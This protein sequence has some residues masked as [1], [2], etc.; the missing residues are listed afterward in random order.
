[1]TAIYVSVGLLLISAAF[2]AGWA[3][4]SRRATREL[5]QWHYVTCAAYI[6]LRKCLDERRDDLRDYLT[7]QAEIQYRCWRSGPRIDPPPFSRDTD[8]LFAVAATEFAAQ[9]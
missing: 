9:D 7:G 8:Q 5:F 3:F 1:M 4:G 2:V 6:G